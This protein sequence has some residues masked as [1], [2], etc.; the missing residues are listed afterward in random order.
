[1][2]AY[3]ITQEEHDAQLLQ[4]LLPQELLEDVSFVVEEG[5][6]S[7][8]SLARSLIVRRRVPVALMMDA[9]TVASELIAERRQSTTELLEIVAGGIPYRVVMAVPEMEGIY[10]QA[11]SLIERVYGQNV[12]GSILTLSR[13]SPKAALQELSAQLQTAPDRTTLL[14][15]LTSQD[16]ESMRESPVIQE[17]SEFLVLARDWV[18]GKTKVTVR[19]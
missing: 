11:P 5:L 15:A 3:V 13:I 6:S 14:D 7:A 16:M 4:R 10:F 8:K 1:M 17:L 9:D 18:E 2:I 12:S 19:A